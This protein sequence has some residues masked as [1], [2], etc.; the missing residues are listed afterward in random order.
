MPEHN[1]LTGS[2]LHEPKGIDSATTGDAGKVLT[3]SSSTAGEGELRLLA[4]SEVTD[5]PSY[6]TVFLPE[7]D[8]TTEFYIPVPM[9][10]DVTGIYTATDSSF[11]GADQT[12]TC[13]INGTG[14]TS[15]VVTITQSGSAAGDVDTATPSA[16]N[17]VTAGD[18]LQVTSG[19]EAT[20]TLNVYISFVI[21]RD[22][23]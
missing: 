18:Y 10:G 14:I 22:G 4:D 9:A 20:S 3:P 6:I 16:N 2:S 8:T 19:A 11:T 23:S 21:E 1:S 12:L 15:G 13:K 5:K 7:V 17:A